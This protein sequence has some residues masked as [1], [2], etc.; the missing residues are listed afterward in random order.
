METTKKDLEYYRKNAEE[1]YL[2]TPISVIRYITE[3]EQALRIHNVVRQSEQLCRCGRLSGRFYA[4]I[5]D[6]ANKLQDGKTVGVVGLKE[7]DKYLTELIKLGLEVKTEPMIKRTPN[8]LMF[9]EMGEPI[10]IKYGEQVQTGWVF[11]YCG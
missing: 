2:T 1:D 6:M 5:I 8:T 11:S 3:M 10:D 4:Q 9:D 7:P